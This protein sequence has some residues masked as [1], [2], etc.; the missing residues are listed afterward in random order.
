MNDQ[1]ELHERRRGVSPDSE[2]QL[3]PIVTML[4]RAYHNRYDE[5]VV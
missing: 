4:L 2:A 3:L 1:G 5:P